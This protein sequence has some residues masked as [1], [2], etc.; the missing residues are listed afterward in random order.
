[1]RIIIFRVFGLRINRL[2]KE[3][4]TDIIV[5]NNVV[6][7]YTF[8]FTGFRDGYYLS[9]GFKDTFIVGMSNVS[10]IFTNINKRLVFSFKLWFV[11][12][13]TTS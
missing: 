9:I 12:T 7:N 10:K 3:I 11:K 13:H 8:V 6:K 5:F 4:S 2:E 1:V